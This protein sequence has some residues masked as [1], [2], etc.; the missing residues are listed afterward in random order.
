MQRTAQ[1][2][3]ERSKQELICCS[4]LREE[5]QR[6]DDVTAER[7]TH[8]KKGATNFFLKWRT[9]VQGEWKGGDAGRFV[10]NRSKSILVQILTMTLS[11][12]YNKQGHRSRPRM[13]RLLVM[14]VIYSD[15]DGDSTHCHRPLLER[16]FWR[17]TVAPSWMAYR[18]QFWLVLMCTSK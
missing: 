7:R 9:I 18:T 6:E 15:D 5:E 16:V 4:R 3:S 11:S 12:L 14:V 10:A 1:I 17:S 2:D 8:H 13:R